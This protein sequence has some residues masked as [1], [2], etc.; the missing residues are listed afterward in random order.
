MMKKKKKKKKKMK[1]KK[2]KKNKKKKNQGLKK[3]QAFTLAAL[4]AA[5]TLRVPWWLTL[6]YIS[7]G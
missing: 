2:M 6:S 3:T 4:H 1:K 7:W 5:T